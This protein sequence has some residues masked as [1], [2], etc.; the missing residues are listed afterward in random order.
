VN[1][2][3][4]AV[5]VADQEPETFAGFMQIHGE[6]AGQL[7]QPRSG[8]VGSDARRMWTWRVAC[9]TAKNT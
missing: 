2:V 7:G 5:A 6:V 4:V 9:S 1:F 3:A 8:R